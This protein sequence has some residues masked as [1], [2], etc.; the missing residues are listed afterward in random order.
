MESLDPAQ[1]PAREDY[2]VAM[3]LEVRRGAISSRRSLLFMPQA[4]K[5]FPGFITPFGSSTRL[6]P[7]I[8]LT[9]SALRVPSR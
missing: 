7:R 1:R 5:T 4:S 2:R 6:M 3:A 8:S 9:S